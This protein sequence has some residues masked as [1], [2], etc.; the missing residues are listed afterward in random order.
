[1]M[2]LMVDPQL[3]GY[4]N[5]SELIELATIARDCVQEDATSRPTMREVVQGME[6]KLHLDA[7]VLESMD[8]IADG[9]SAPVPASSS[10]DIHHG[11][12]HHHGPWASVE[13]FA[14]SIRQA[15]SGGR[16]AGAAQSDQSDMEM[17]SS[18]LMMR[19]GSDR[20]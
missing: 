8:D 12:T 5:Q 1:M 4:F 15:L 11:S 17:A 16:G 20:R 3:G 13:N 10:I 18:L 6:E 9:Y 14:T 7:H 2:P 19:P